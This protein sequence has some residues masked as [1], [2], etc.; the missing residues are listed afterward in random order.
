M[1]HGRFPASVMT[2][3]QMGACK[4]SEVERY[5]VH[6]SDR[7]MVK[8]GWRNLQELEKNLR[9]PGGDLPKG[10]RVKRAMDIVIASGTLLIA[11]PIMI[12]VAALIYLKMGR[13]VIFSHPRVGF[14]GSIFHCYKFR[15][16]VSDADKRLNDYLARDPD[17]RHLWRE[18]QKLRRDPRVTP[19]GRLLRQSSLD[20]LPQL[21]NI[22]RGDMSCIGPR[23]VTVGELQERFGSLARYY[24][25]AR[26]GLAGL[27]QVSGRSSLSYRDRVTLDCLYVRK[28]SLLLDLKILLRTLPAVLKTRD[29]A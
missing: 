27:W 21:I 15:T 29:A 10:G 13:P 28:W 26:P 11:A 4:M 14:N 20:E 6:P 19:L 23:P 24:K 8:T 25:M 16:M 3:I 9:R 12:G 2:G 17:A 7:S 5:F 18:T 22:L 1:A